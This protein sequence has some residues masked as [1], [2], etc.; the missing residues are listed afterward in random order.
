[1]GIEPISK[2][3]YLL[4]TLGFLEA[5]PNA[6]PKFQNQKSRGFRYFFNRLCRIESL[7]FLDISVLILRCEV[8]IYGVYN[9]WIR[10]PSDS[11]YRCL[12]PSEVKCERAER[13]SKAMHTYLWQALTLAE[14]VDLDVQGIWLGLDQEPVSALQELLE[15]RYDDRYDAL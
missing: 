2:S 9:L 11:H 3:L 8:R 1:M 5:L 14:M 13:M 10:P 15:P 4:K 6:L 7:H 12:A